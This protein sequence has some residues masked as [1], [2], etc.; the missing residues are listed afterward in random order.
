MI[1]PACQMEQEPTNPLHVPQAALAGALLAAGSPFVAVS[2]A[3]ADD[4]AG[5]ALAEA[6]AVVRRLVPAPAAWLHQ[7]P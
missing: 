3:L 2:A 5:E 1:L 7:P 6:P 4:F